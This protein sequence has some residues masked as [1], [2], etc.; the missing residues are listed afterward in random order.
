MSGICLFFFF[1]LIF[2]SNSKNCLK[3]A[4]FFICYDKF[5]EE[6][7]RLRRSWYIVDENNI[8]DAIFVSLRVYGIING[9]SIVLEQHSLTT[10]E[11]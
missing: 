8:F 11:Y 1:F 10:L 5:V 9:P 6:S 4:F 2:F 7:R 3:I